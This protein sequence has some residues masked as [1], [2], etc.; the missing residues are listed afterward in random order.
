MSELNVPKV[1]GT[2]IV[3]TELYAEM[4]RYRDYEFR[5]ATWFIAILIAILGFLISARFGR[6]GDLSVF[7]NA[8]VN[9]CLLKLALIAGTGLLGF[10]SCYLVWYA[11]S[12]YD[13]LRQQ[14]D[15]LEPDWRPRISKRV[16]QPRHIL[17]ATPV[18]VV[19]ITWFVVLLPRC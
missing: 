11:G 18:V 14:A 1:E 15:K 17:Y 6:A 9:D 13:E 4:R 8:M 7:G 3:Y 12:R 16:F 2:N 5:S 19:L 10:T